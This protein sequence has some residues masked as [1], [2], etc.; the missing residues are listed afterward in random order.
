VISHA[1]EKGMGVA[2]MGPVG[3][4]R[5]AGTGPDFTSI[6][7]NSFGN[8][9]S[10][11]LKFVWSNP[12]VTT[13]LSGMESFEVLDENVKLAKNFTPL[14][15]AQCKKADALKEKLEGL[16]DIYC[17]GC[18]YCLPCEQKVNIPGIFNLLICHEV[19]GAEKYAKDMYRLIG[20]LPLI[21]GKNASHC[22]ECGECEEKCPQE[23]SIMEQLKR[24]HELLAYL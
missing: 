4:G 23:I 15:T 11:A 16:R 14:T 20:L 19:F 22:I 24:S 18:R 12:F 13:A 3:G 7:P 8:A 1:S 6:I 2:I 21:P 5:L 17:S 9:P 10:L